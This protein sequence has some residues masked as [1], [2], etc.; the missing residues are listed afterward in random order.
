MLCASGLLAMVRKNVLLVRSSSVP[1]LIGACLVSYLLGRYTASRPFLP[2]LEPRVRGKG[3]LCG[4]L[5]KFSVSCIILNPE[6][7]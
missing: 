3:C 4:V 5:P 7:W 1:L 6:M 2:D